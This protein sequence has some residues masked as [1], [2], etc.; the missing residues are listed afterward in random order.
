MSEPPDARAIVEAKLAA[1]GIA[2]SAEEVDAL[3]AGYPA[4]RAGADALY[5]VPEARYEEPA[6]VFD[7]DPPLADWS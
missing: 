3:A 7:A 4:L 1:A 5:A 2:P 6:L